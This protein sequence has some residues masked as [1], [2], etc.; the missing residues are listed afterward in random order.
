MPPQIGFTSKLQPTEGGEADGQR[1]GSSA[2]RQARAM[3]IPPGV[4][5]VQLA[6]AQRAR[7]FRRNSRESKAAVAGS[8]RL[9]E[10]PNA[11][12]FDRALAIDLVR[13]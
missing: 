5:T 8:P 6:V 11:T 9:D 10:L 12:L 1:S 4:N 7:N 3:S 2:R 13:R